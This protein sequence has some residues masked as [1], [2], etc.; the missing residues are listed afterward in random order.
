MSPTLDPPPCPRLF[1]LTDITSVEAGVREPD[2]AQ[3]LV[4]LLLYANEIQIEGLYATS[5]LGHGHACRPENVA[6]LVG[7]Y[8]KDW[9]SLVRH[10]ARYTPRPTILPSTPS[11]CPGF[12]ATPTFGAGF[13]KSPLYGFGCSS[14]CGFATPLSTPGWNGAVDGPRR[15]AGVGLL[16]TSFG[17]V[18]APLNSHRR[19]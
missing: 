16:Y 5:G 10:D 9:P 13:M 14:T 12:H 15:S 18:A 11:G 1:V 8:E 6:A 19:P 2:D 7:A 4:R 17:L 3:S